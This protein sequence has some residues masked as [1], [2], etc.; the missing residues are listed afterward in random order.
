MVFSLAT[1]WLK[2]RIVQRVGFPEKIHAK[3]Y[4][5]SML[6]FTF[7]VYCTAMWRE[8]VPCSSTSRGLVGVHP[9]LLWY[10]DFRAPG[11]SN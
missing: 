10:V 3:V 6:Y 7:G 2:V 8:L 4:R 5:S 1:T 9:K 11:S